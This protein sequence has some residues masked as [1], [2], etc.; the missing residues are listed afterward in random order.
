M[1][2]E[3]DLDWMNEYIE[4][5]PCSQGLYKL[6]CIILLKRRM[7]YSNMYMLTYALQ[8]D[9][10]KDD[11]MLLKEK[12]LKELATIYYYNNKKFPDGFT[13]STE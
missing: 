2:N 13:V 7:T 4:K 3:F 11:E 5:V 12:I 1:I 9:K 6:L 8:K 10:Y